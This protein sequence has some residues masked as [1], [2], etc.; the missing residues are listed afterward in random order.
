MF[1]REAMHFVKVKSAILNACE[2]PEVQGQE[3]CMGT[4]GCREMIF[5]LGVEGRWR[6]PR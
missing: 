4:E 3:S 1:Q 2:T 5:K 6:G